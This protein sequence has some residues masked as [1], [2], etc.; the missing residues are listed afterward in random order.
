MSDGIVEVAAV[1]GPAAVARPEPDARA[2]PPEAVGPAELAQDQMS[3]ESHF[4]NLR[5][6]GR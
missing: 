4:R 2:E 1:V 6:N 5:R 3:A